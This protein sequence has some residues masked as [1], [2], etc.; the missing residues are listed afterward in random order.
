MS[1]K[2][3]WKRYHENEFSSFGTCAMCVVFR[4]LEIRDFSVVL[5]FVFVVTKIVGF[6]GVPMAPH[7][8]HIANV[9]ATV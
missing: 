4:E 1:R 7:S 6:Y 2:Y 9:S 8:V 3:Y 5:E